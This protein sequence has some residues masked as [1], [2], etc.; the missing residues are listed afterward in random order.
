MGT[1]LH[2]LTWGGSDAA[3][4]WALHLSTPGTNLS[5]T[6]SGLRVSA[7]TGTDSGLK[8]WSNA[9][10]IGTATAYHKIDTQADGVRQ[11]I[12]PNTSGTLLPATVKVLPANISNNSTTADA[13]PELSYAGPYGL[14]EFSG[15]LILSVPVATTGVT[16]K[17][18]GG[19]EISRAHVILTGPGASRTDINSANPSGFP[20]IFSSTAS[21]DT[22]P[23]LLRIAG[24]F[25]VDGPQTSG[26]QI[27]YATEV[28][29]SSVTIQKDSFVRYQWIGA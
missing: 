11:V 20:A 17:L 12:L 23:Y 24:M 5:T 3:Y 8:L 10:G 7:G 22:S 21:P 25:R 4:Q 15:C 2:N 28:F 29:G 13:V 9:I 19:S 27:S 14:Y 16:V 26:I 1:S 6:S 18:D